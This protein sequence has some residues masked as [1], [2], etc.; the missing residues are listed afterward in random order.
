MDPSSTHSHRLEHV[1]PNTIVRPVSRSNINGRISISPPFPLTD[2]T[3]VRLQTWQE[4]QLT[5]PAWEQSLLLC[6]IIHE[7]IRLRRALTQYSSDTIMVVSDG[8]TKDNHGAY[9]WEMEFRLI[10]LA[11]CYAT[12]S[13]CPNTVLRSECFGILSWSLFLLRFCEF[14]PSPTSAKLDTFSDSETATKYTAMPI[15]DSNSIKPLRPDYDVTTTLT[16]TFHKLTRQLPLLSP[17]QPI[18]G[19]SP[20][21]SPQTRLLHDIDIR[22]KAKRSLQH[23]NP[24]IK[25]GPCASY[26]VQNSVVISSK[27]INQCRWSWRNKLLFQFYARKFRIEHPTVLR[28]H[29]DAYAIAKSALSA[30]MKR[31]TVKLTIGWL[32]VGERLKYY[33]NEIDSCHLCP[34]RE[35]PFHLFQC[36][37]H[38]P[39][40]IE[41]HQAFQ[42]FLQSI[43]TPNPIVTA[44]SDGILFWATSANQTRIDTARSTLPTH[45]LQCVHRQDSTGWSIAT[46][47]VMDISWS[48]Q[49]PDPRDNNSG[50][51]WQSAVS[52][53]LIAQAHTLWMTRNTERNNPDP[54]ALSRAALRET[55]AQVNR[56]FTLSER[57]PL[58]DRHEL[59]R[60]TLEERLLKV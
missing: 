16:E 44:L 27:D 10:T 59:I 9:G 50:L 24:N 13:G 29:W 17:I 2:D 38:T 51:K 19:H 55:E 49:I 26:L 47:G 56:I 22:T 1:L 30:A 36:S 58:Y 23:K 8:S 15:H 31:F 12:T 42:L 5:L 25:L 6:P 11:S 14:L 33:G 48:L 18:P 28:I 21:Y 52:S 39:F 20:D 54:L 46:F 53:W 60:S 41:R 35:T 3:I 32:P 7:P 40:F 4:F 45:I 34:S 37:H 43:D 57:L